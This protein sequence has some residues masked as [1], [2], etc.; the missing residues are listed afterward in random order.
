MIEEPNKEVLRLTGEIAELTAVYIMD[1]GVTP[2]QALAALSAV[3]V[4]VMAGMPQAHDWLAN[5]RAELARIKGQGW[6]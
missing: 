1:K 2:P 5:L 4:R 3:A 6:N